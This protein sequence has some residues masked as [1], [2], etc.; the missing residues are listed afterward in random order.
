MIPHTDTLHAVSKVTA[1]SLQKVYDSR[2]FIDASLLQWIEFGRVHMGI[3]AL[4]NFV[5]I[6]TLSLVLFYGVFLVLKALA[7]LVKEIAGLVGRTTKS[8]VEAI[9]R[10]P[11]RVVSA[12][13]RVRKERQ[14]FQKKIDAAMLQAQTEG[15]VESPEGK[16]K[17][18]LVIA[19][20]P[21]TIEML[22][23]PYVKFCKPG[24]QMD[25]F[26]RRSL[27]TILLTVAVSH[28]QNEAFW[29]ES[30]SQESNPGR[31]D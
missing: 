29:S 15:I 20:D 21:T 31:K 2:G 3:W 28:A 25:Q 30:G 9:F 26:L 16:G 6:T 1:D 14:D 12:M 22:A 27:D 8:L 23:E 7:L 11:D 10:I 4:V 13:F 5:A 19:L 24:E 18:L 17:H